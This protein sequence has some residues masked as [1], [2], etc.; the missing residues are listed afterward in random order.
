MQTTAEKTNRDGLSLLETILA[1]DGSNQPV[2]PL[3][4]GGRVL[5]ATLV[6]LGFTLAERASVEELTRRLLYVEDFDGN[7]SIIWY[8]EPETEWME[9]FAKAWG[10]HIIGEG[11][12]TVSH[13]ALVWDAAAGRCN[14]KPLPRIAG[15]NRCQ[16][17]CNAD[18]FNLPKVAALIDDE[19][20]AAR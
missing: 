8:G 9:A 11:K 18:I 4:R 20:S 16:L 6:A 7:L 12:D 13:A 19:T 17:F 2:R 10:S 5:A 15:V 14:L 3:M 1:K